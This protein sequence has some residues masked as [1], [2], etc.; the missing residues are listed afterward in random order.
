M[1]MQKIISISRRTDVPR[2]Y[3]EQIVG[4]FKRGY[5]ELVN[6]F[7]CKPYRVE[8]D[9]NDIHTIVWWSKDF[10]RWFD[11]ADFFDKKMPNVN[12]FFHFT[13]NGYNEPI[14]Q[15]SLEP[16]ITTPLS[17]RLLQVKRLCDLFR[18]EQITW[19]FDPIVFWIDP[20]TREMR[21]NTTNF[22][23]IARNVSHFGIKR[24]AISVVNWYGKAE[25]RA[26]KRHFEFV[27]PTKEEEIETVKR[28]A[29]INKELGIDSFSCSFPDIVMHGEVLVRPSKCIDADLLMRLFGGD[30]SRAKDPGQREACGCTK[31]IDIGSYEMKCGHGC[32][33]CY[34]RPET[35]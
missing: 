20:E 11:Y 35:Q 24:C 4:D 18:P 1:I 2:W 22:E 34:A 25:R 7:N 27:R 3:M 29:K 28:M 13:I 14:V 19:R 21:D 10:S 32:V 15:R 12:H 16:G 8:L 6:P 23:T 26:V 30:L 31:S 9:R 17:N 5:A 33:Y